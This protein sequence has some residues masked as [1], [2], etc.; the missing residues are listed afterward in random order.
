M[1]M[2]PPG[3]EERAYADGVPDYLARAQAIKWKE[4]AKGYVPK[5]PAP[6][7]PSSPPAATPKA[8]SPPPAR[9]PKEPTS[10]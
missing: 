8:P 10:K 4:D 3:L 6:Q 7:A 1:A 9:A 5:P 2:A